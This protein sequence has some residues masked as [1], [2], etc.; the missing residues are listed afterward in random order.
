MLFLLIVNLLLCYF[1]LLLALNY[2]LNYILGLSVLYIIIYR[3]RLGWSKCNLLLVY[4]LTRR[5][6][7]YISCG[8]GGRFITSPRTY[9][10]PRYDN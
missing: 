8:T 10:L 5:A 1:C 4:L 9:I 6:Y 7:I 3:Y 2:L